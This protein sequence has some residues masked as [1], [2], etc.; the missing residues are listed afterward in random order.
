[1]VLE[2][3]PRSLLNP[4]IHSVNSG[5]KEH[6]V[7]SVNQVNTWLDVLEEHTVSWLEDHILLEDHTVYTKLNK[8]GKDNS[9]EA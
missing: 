7:R 6:S 2:Q 5:F 1:M 3:R 4:F 8:I 9:F